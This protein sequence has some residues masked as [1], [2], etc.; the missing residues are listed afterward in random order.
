MSIG[1]FIK[2][3]LIEDRGKEV[4]RRLE[5]LHKDIDIDSLEEAIRYLNYEYTQGF[6]DYCDLDEL[7]KA[8]HKFWRGQ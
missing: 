5:N 1:N 8:E 2:D 3:L 4:F 6:I 7:V